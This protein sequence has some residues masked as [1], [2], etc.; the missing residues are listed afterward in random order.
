MA[1]DATDDGW[2]R[3]EGKAARFGEMLGGHWHRVVDGVGELR[4]DP[5]DRHLNNNGFLHGGYL[6]SIADQALFTIARGRLSREVGAVTLTC[7]SEFLGA[8]VAGKPIFAT[9]EVLRETG[10][11]LFI[12]GLLSQAGEPILAF[13]GTLRKVPRRA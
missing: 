10:K 7:N 8:G 12:R 9:G 2:I 6:M 4:A 3:W 13:S 11:M 5:E 1:T